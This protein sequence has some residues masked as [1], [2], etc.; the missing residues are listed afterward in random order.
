MITRKAWAALPY[1]PMPN[2]DPVLNTE[3]H[4]CA[5]HK[6]DAAEKKAM[7]I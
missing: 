6:W 1:N 5:I 2:D 4:P 7:Q 3:T